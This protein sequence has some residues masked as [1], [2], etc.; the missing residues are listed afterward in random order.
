[1][2]TPAWR[3][4]LRFWQSDVEDDVDEEL[5][6]HVDMREQEYVASGRAPD[7][8]H[9]AALDRFGDVA[10]VRDSCY[11]I[12]YRRERRAR[13]ADVLHS[14]WMDAVFALRQLAHNRG[15]TVAA[16]L[17][18]ALGIG[19][20]GLVLGL[21]NAILLRPLAGVTAPEQLIAMDYAVSYPGY[22]D[23]RES[24][25]ALSGLAAFRHR[26]TAVSVGHR[27]D[28]APVGVVS[29]NYFQVLGV[30]PIRGRVLTP[31]DDDPAAPGVAVL[32]TTFART[33]FP[34]VEDPVGKVID[35][36]G[37]PVAVVGIVPDAFHGTRLDSPETVWISINAW[38]TVAPS[39]LRN[40]N[41][42]DRGM[43]WLHMVGRLKDGTTIDQAAAALNTSARRQAEAFPD[44]SGGLAKV[45]STHRPTSANQDAISE[46]PHRTII[47]S[48]AIVST[49]VAIVLLIACAN[50]SNL[51]LARAMGRRREFA[52]RM[53]V[54]AGRAR[55][56]RQLLTETAVLAL[57][58]AIA[59]AVA[60][61]AVI[62][63]LANATL[64]NGL[65][66]ADLHVRFDGRL[67]ASMIMISL[68]ASIGFGVAP[69]LQGTRADM[70]S[71]LKDGVPGAG[72][73]RS[74]LRRILLVA[75][76]S[77]SLTLLI[78]AGLFIRSLQ[79]ALATDPGFDGTR[80]ATGTI[81]IGLIH[82]DSARA[83]Q[84]YAAATRKLRATPGVQSVGWGSTLPLD[85]SGDF[86]TIST[87]GDASQTRGREVEFSF[88]SPGFLEAFSI[89][90]VRGRLFNDRDGP[91]APH[92]AVVNQTMA[93]QLWH[94]GN[95]LGK[96]VMFDD[97]TVTVVGV[98]RDIKYHELD[99]S[100][101]PF[102]YRAFNQ[103]SAT[104]RLAPQHLVVRTAGKPQAIV[105]AIPQLLR[106]VAPE[107]PVYDVSA[108][109]ARP[110]HTIFAQQM[111]AA[112]LGLFGILALTITAI[113]IYGVVGYG[114]TQRTREI[115]IRIA[116]GARARRVLQ[117]V[118]FDNLA[119]MIAGVAIGLLLSIAL[120]RGMSS[121]L[122]GV[123]P[124]DAVTFIVAS[125]VLVVI[126]AVASMIPA[127]RATRVDPIVALR[128]D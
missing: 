118:V 126:G 109:G 15:F 10:A 79:H 33:L 55:I 11:T 57:V 85:Q 49:V 71:A 64:P 128:S 107:V 14:V 108:F 63:A 99:E 27:T 127:V 121:F 7:E 53:A 90:L 72:R 12:A 51:L 31:V 105:A 77:L 30:S 26:V 20:N 17:T 39:W 95:P 48:A 38:A 45:V 91:T 87:D 112:V 92:V 16:V 89:P 67:L 37:V 4:Y 56:I 75:Q 96:R 25:P 61:F 104:S 68:V 83:D 120:T 100:P 74:S 86:A 65:A 94:N 43:H 70:T 82:G 54:G 66:F 116:L 34:G 24:N 81:S 47:R 9:A 58:S 29:G 80:V 97:D 122:F 119:T 117:L 125:L 18:L 44:E 5:R 35:L 59:G 102:I 106:D 84:I 73:S 32:N 113:G 1:M 88:V 103:G 110:G 115:G 22:R 13:F 19:A 60:T 98:I 2:N 46:I 76:I 123:S 8:A 50:I 21:V 101:A 69:A 6:F 41:T 114:V 42:E 124:V 40:M 111:G 52:V 93:R 3:R 36:N 78:G 23:F 62:H 28:M